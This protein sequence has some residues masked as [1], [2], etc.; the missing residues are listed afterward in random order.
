[1]VMKKH[2][3]KGCVKTLSPRLL[4]PTP[5]PLLLPLFL[6]YST[7]SPPSSPRIF[8]FLAS[9]RGNNSNGRRDLPAASLVIHHS[10]FVGIVAQWVSQQRPELSEGETVPRR[11]R[12]S[13]G[14]FAVIGKVDSCAAFGKPSDILPTLLHLRP[15]PGVAGNV[16]E[17]RRERCH[18]GE[19]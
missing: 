15:G 7:R 14:A 10:L 9:C 19:L 11:R 5:S 4:L 16:N 2:S 12:M 17:S 1:M 18:C 8:S 3:N 6:F 13:E